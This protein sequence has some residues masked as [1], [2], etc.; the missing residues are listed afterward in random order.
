MAKEKVSSEL[1][2]RILAKSA[3]RL[4]A[5]GVEGEDDLLEIIHRK[6]EAMQ[7]AGKEKL[8]V[9]FTHTIKVDFSKGT[10][11]DT[12]GGS[13]KVALVLEGG[14]DDPDQGK[15]FGEEDGIDD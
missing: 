14:I 12:L 7:E 15:L 3:K 4:V 13:M 5:L 9:S 6:A 10:Q 8:V 1:L 11:T 2:Q